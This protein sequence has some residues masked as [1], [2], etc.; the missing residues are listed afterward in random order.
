MIFVTHP[1]KGY[2]G[3]GSQSSEVEIKEVEPF[4]YCSISNQGAST[5]IQDLIN[6]L[7][8][9]LRKQNIAPAGNMIAIY[10]ANRETAMSESM[11]WEMGFP[12]HNTIL[13]QP[14]LSKKQW[15]HTL[16]A[17]ATH[18]GSYETT[19]QTI[20]MMLDWIEENDYVQ[21]GPMMG[22]YTQTLSENTTLQ[23]LRTEI[24][25]PVKEK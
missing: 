22:K 20:D 9:W 16:V 8:D 19:N 4:T 15:T 18:S 3:H 7:M 5:N 17:V 11:E 1:V 23:D 21:D 14:P 24:W 2:T 25:I 13:A 10:P 12:V 6:N